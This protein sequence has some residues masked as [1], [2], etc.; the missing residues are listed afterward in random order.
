MSTIS[1]HDRSHLVNPP[2]HKQ[3]Q[4]SLQHFRMVIPNLLYVIGLPVKYS[5]ENLLKQPAFFGQF[6]KISRIVIN[7]FTKDYYE[8]QGQ[9]AVYIWYDSPVQVALAISCLNGLRLPNNKFLKCSFGTS[10][11]CMNFLKDARCETFES[12]A[13]CPFLHYV[14]RRRDKVIQDDIEFKEFLVQ[15]DFIAREFQ[16]LLGLKEQEK[17]SDFYF[18]GQGDPVLRQGFPSI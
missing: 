2:L 14:E 8:Q 6:G 7:S 12:G 18:S 5:S 4:Q 9:C 3:M 17:K 11:Y 10:K 13:R 1:S 15:Q 16:K